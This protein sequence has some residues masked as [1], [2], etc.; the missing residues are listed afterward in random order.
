MLEILFLLVFAFILMFTG[1][2]MISLVAATVVGFVIML[3]AG[4]V[5]VML[6]ML[7]WIIVIA[8]CVW[9]CKHKMSDQ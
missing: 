9:F 6:K 7:P 1:V 2:T 4:M 5:G 3:L 8:V